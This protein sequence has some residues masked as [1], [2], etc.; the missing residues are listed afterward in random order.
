MLK[1]HDKW[2]DENICHDNQQSAN[3]QLI[4]SNELIWLNKVRSQV[5][6]SHIQRFH[7]L[8]ERLHQLDS[9]ADLETSESAFAIIYRDDGIKWE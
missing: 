4:Q 8:F 5:S 7:Q 1:Q 2:L 9:L 6:Y 3:S